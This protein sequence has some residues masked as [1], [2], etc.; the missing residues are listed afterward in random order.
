MNDNTVYV[1]DARRYSRNGEI[2]EHNVHVYSSYQN[3]IAAFESF[4]KVP[5]K[6]V[7]MN[8]KNEM[9]QVRIFDPTNEFVTKYKFDIYENRSIISFQKRLNISRLR[10]QI[11]SVALF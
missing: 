1:I 3:V 6:E 2:I 10:R 4:F 5:N 9:L 11:D 7:H 8:G